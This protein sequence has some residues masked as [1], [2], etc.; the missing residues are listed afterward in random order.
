[1]V[2]TPENSILHISSIWKKACRSFIHQI[3]V[4]SPAS[5][6]RVL[7]V[8]WRRRCIL[9]LSEAVF[10]RCLS[11]PLG[12]KSSSNPVCVLMDFLLDNLSIA[13]GGELESTTITVSLPS[14]PLILLYVW[15]LWCCINDGAL[16]F[17]AKGSLHHEDVVNTSSPSICVCMYFGISIM[18]A[19]R[20]SVLTLV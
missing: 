8:C 3:L 14:D 16:V 6:R 5:S 11:G 18:L 13:D 10:Y 12:L 4:A 15:V 20:Y 19:L 9:L 7:P 1:M 2:V 17:M